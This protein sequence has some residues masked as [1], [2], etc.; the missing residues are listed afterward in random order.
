MQMGR[1]QQLLNSL[2]QKPLAPIY[3]ISSLQVELTN[4]GSI[5]ISYKPLI[6]TA[7]QLLRRET[8]FNRLLSFNRCTRRILLPFL[9][10]ALSWLT[11]TATT[12]E[13]NSIKN[14]VNQ[15]IAMQHKQETLV[16]IISVLNVTRYVTLVNR[17]HTN[18]VMDTVERTCHDV[19]TLYNIINSLYTSL[20]YQQIV[21]HICSILAN[22]RYSLYYMR[23]VIMH[24]MDYIDAATAGILSPHVPAVEDLRKMLIHIKEALPST[25]HLSVSLEDTIHFYRY[26]STH[27]LITDKQFLLVIDVPIQDHT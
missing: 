15:L 26:L 9:G 21:L 25:M 22:L 11:G 27:V 2:Q 18:L 19:T 23:Q 16:H 24:A 12:K 3:M 14:R 10:D 13:V 20:N 4:L 5:Y 17:Q 6:L 1:K 7:T 8:T